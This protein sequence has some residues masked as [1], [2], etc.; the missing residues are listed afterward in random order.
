MSFKNNPTVTIISRTAIG[1]LII[2]INALMLKHT[3]LASIKQ[4]G[5]NAAPDVAA[6]SYQT[7][8]GSSAPPSQ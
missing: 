3:K 2:T 8:K 1:T 5:K 4:P 7:V 6:E